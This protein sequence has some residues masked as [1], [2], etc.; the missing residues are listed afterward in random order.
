MTRNVVAEERA[1]RQGPMGRRLLLDRNADPER[2]TTVLD[3]GSEP[4]AK[5]ARAGKQID[6]AES[7]RQ[8]RLLTNFIQPVYTRFKDENQGG[9][10][11]YRGPT[12]PFPDD[13]GNK[14]K[15]HQARAG[16]QA[17]I[18]RARFPLPASFQQGSRST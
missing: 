5:S 13:V 10:D 2:R 4:L 8:I 6:N 17:G 7:G 12:D 15:E 18:A 16:S 11:R 14:G 3:E 9:C 1:Q